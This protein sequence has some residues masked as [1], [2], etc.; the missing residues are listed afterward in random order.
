MTSWDPWTQDDPWNSDPIP[1]S[2]PR[3]VFGSHVVDLSGP[4]GRGQTA[5]FPPL[6]R[7]SDP[8]S[9]P[10]RD[11]VNPWLG[12]RPRWAMTSA[13]AVTPD[14]A[15]AAGSSP[16]SSLSEV[17]AS[18]TA[19]QTSP[20]AAAPAD[21]SLRWFGGPSFHRYGETRE[22]FLQAARLG[23]GREGLLVDPGAY[24][25][26]V[27]SDTQLAHWHRCRACKAPSD[28]WTSLWGSMT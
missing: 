8:F 5:K 13:S 19:Q 23:E 15:A 25:N 20:E 21:P 11:D 6:G 1:S 22:V 24:L 18:G 12:Y 10:D 27:G 9:E 2:S 17:P 4:Q 7:R 28:R 14:A 3:S 26:V 16:D